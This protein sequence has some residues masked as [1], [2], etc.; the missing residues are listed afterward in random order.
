MDWPLLADMTPTRARP[1]LPYAADNS[2]R[3]ID[4]ERK[5]QDRPPA[6][7]PRERFSAGSAV[8]DRRTP[9]EQEQGAS[10]QH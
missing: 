7:L 4:V 5:E 9:F 2:V 1:L 3:V 6:K 10:Q 8:R